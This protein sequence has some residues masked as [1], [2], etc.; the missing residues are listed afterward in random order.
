M[1]AATR[2]CGPAVRVGRCGVERV[3]DDAAHPHPGKTIETLRERVRVLERLALQDELTGLVNRHGL[4]AFGARRLAAARDAGT[5][6]VVMVF[7]VDGL[8]TINDTGGHRDGDEALR[9]V[10][11]ALSEVFG[12]HA[13]LARIGGDEFVALFEASR[14]TDPDALLTRLEQA[15]AARGPQGRGLRISAGR[16]MRAA[17]DG[18][19]LMDSV[20]EA[21]AAMYLGRRLGGL[22]LAARA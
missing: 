17:N 19:P 5:G 7:D 15:L 18:R 14:F 11:D 8:K 12:P 9:D 16:A 20:H 6:L 10:A 4:R 13:L 21:D 2:A 22:E 1:T 3:D